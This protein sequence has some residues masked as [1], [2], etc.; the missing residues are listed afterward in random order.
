MINDTNNGRGMSRR[1]VLGGAAALAAGLVGASLAG[2][3][4]ADGRTDRVRLT[5]PEPTGPHEIGTV[6]LHLV[7]H[8]RQDPWL[9]TPRP[10]ELMVSMWYPAR[11]DGDCRLAPWRTP[12]ALAF[13][14]ERKAL[15]L[16][17]S[18]DNVDYPVT[19]GREG[20]PVAR[21]AQPYPVVFY[22]P[23]GHE[24]RSIGTIQVEDLAS[25]GYVVVTISHTYNAGEVEFPG[26]RVEHGQVFQGSPP[27]GYDGLT[28][29]ASVILH[30]R[31]A[32]FVLDQITALNAGRNPDAGHRRLPDG[33]CRSM[34]LSRVGMFGHSFGGATTMQTL[35][36]DGR[37]RAGI[38]LDGSPVPE[39]PLL[40]NPQ[41][42]AE[43]TAAIARRIGDRPFLVTSSMGRGPDSLG[44]LTSGFW[45]GLT[46]WRR[47]LSLVGSAHGSYVDE[48]W[49][50]NQMFAAGVIPN[51]PPGTIDP[52]RSVAA[53]RAYLGAFFDLWLR[54]RDNHLLDGPS[55]SYPEVLFF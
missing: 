28:S 55:A 30:R 29:D 15:D 6:S 17:A 37:F 31:D 39:V 26:G 22:S 10:R 27:P 45:H 33:L 13:Y 53:Q 47:F 54:G 5:L 51:R 50:H 52:V 44:A 32:Q 9:S 2:T 36:N 21:S 19:H 4:R 48:G 8:G 35:A 7:D 1:R 18:L 40:G 16:G 3:A 25:H 49:L 42:D 41:Q 12:A 43:L 23:S 14:R 11:D 46:G 34:D 24:D 20:A 38:N